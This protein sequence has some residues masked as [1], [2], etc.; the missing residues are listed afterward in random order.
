MPTLSDLLRDMR[1]DAE[2]QPPQGSET[3][4]RLLADQPAIVN[5]MMQARM[6][7]A[8]KNLARPNGVTDPRYPE[9]K[10]SQD[11]ATA[12]LRAADIGGMAMPIRGAIMKA[13]L[14]RK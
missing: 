5:A 11:D 14:E 12:L 1:M 8:R 7:A 2:P 13:L 3:L 10:K 9:W 4:A 6:D